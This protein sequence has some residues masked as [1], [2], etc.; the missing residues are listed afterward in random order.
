MACWDMMELMYCSY[1]YIIKQKES[2]AQR[3][4]V[5]DCRLEAMSTFMPTSMN[6]T[7]A[8]VTAE[9]SKK[10]VIPAMLLGFGL[11]LVVCVFLLL[12]KSSCSSNANKVKILAMVNEEME[13]VTSVSKGGA[14][15]YA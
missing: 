15:R 13:V 7:A 2:T 10:V 3:L 4:C 1:Q 14:S 6:S 9:E 5:V 8:N 12:V 11:F